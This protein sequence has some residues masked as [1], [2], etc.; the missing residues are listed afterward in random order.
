MET[1]GFDFW[2]LKDMIRPDFTFENAQD[3][4]GEVVASIVREVAQNEISVLD[5]WDSDRTGAWK[6]P[7]SWSKFD[8]YT[9]LDADYASSI[10]SEYGDGKVLDSSTTFDFKLIIQVEGRISIKAGDYSEAKK[11]LPGRVFD[12]LWKSIDNYDDYEVR[13]VF[14]SGKVFDFNF[15]SL[16]ETDDVYDD[17]D[18]DE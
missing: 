4:D 12:D 5:A 15:V 9:Y 6:L 13:Q 14:Y 8:I 11:I 3:I 7:D 10:D 1:Y 16:D 2:L 17:E 18:E